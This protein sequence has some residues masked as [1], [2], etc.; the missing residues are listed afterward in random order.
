M[1]GTLTIRFVDLFADTVNTHG[2]RWAH[3]YYAK[4][5]MSDFEY[6]VWLKSARNNGKI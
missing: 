4:R 1:R 3:Q 2:A 6:G 5:G